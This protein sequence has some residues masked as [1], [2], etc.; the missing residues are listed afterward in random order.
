MGVSVVDPV[1]SVPSGLE[2]L[3]PAD[4]VD[5]DDASAF[6]IFTMGH[7]SRAPCP[8]RRLLNSYT[9]PL[10]NQPAEV[11]L[12]LA[13]EP[14]SDNDFRQLPLHLQLDQLL[15]VHLLQS[16]SAVVFIHAQVVRC[17]QNGLSDLSQ[18]DAIVCYCVCYCV[19][20]EERS[21]AFEKPK[22]QSVL[23]QLDD[24]AFVKNK[25]RTPEDVGKRKN[26]MKKLDMQ[27]RRKIQKT[28]PVYKD[29]GLLR[30]AKALVCVNEEDVKDLDTD[31]STEL[32]LRK[33]CE[34]L[35]GDVARCIAVRY[36]QARIVTRIACG[37]PGVI[38]R[39][40]SV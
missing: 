23:L 24:D 2:F 25:I 32:T 21:C 22:S 36:R 34:V 33:V 35:S 37:V 30:Y 14:R 7:S 15:H 11:V 19:S 40:L 12:T 17:K 8:C 31:S 13:P 1:A 5:S 16:T 6:M 4:E 27:R 10:A 3:D 38:G 26:E 20:L 28:L 39:L 9:P 29:I 18:D